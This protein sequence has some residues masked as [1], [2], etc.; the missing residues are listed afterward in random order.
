MRGQAQYAAA[1]TEKQCFESLAQRARDLGIHCRVVV[2]PGL[3]ADEILTFLRS[4]KI[5]CVIMG[6]HTPGPIGKLLVGSVAEAVL[7]SANVP[8]NI[9]GPDVVEG[10]FHNFAKRTILCSVS[11]QGGQ[12]LG[13]ELC[14]GTRSQAQ[15]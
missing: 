6:A 8:V 5:D 12:P 2:R 9:V 1:R 15:C 10:T 13:G 7:R 3:P 4:Q 14:C 11:A